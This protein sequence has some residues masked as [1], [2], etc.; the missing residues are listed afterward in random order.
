MVYVFI[1]FQKYF[2][3]KSDK[4]NFHSIQVF[5]VEGKV[6]LKKAI[7]IFNQTFESSGFGI[8]P[9]HGGN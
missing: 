3:A 7:D 8:T 6:Y 1:N 2:L 9:Y 5:T 4:I